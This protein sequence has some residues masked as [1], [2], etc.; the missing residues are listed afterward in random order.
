[1]QKNINTG[2]FLLK[3]NI[4]FFILLL[5]LNIADFYISSG[6]K[7][8]FTLFSLFINCSLFFLYKIRLS[9]I[10]NK[11]WLHIKKEILYINYPLLIT[12]FF[13]LMFLV[14]S[15][16]I[17]ILA[18]VNKDALNPAF[19]LTFFLST[20]T[21]LTPSIFFLVYIFIVNPALILPSYDTR[22]NKNKSDIIIIILFVIFILASLSKFTTDAINSL[23]IN[24]R[25]KFKAVKLPVSYS[26]K[27]LKYKDLTDKRINILSFDTIKVPLYYTAEG[28]KYNTYEEADFFCKSINARV[29]NHLEIYN[30]IFNRFDTF[31]EQYYWTSNYAGKY[32]LVLHFK[33]MSYEIEMKPKNI[34]PTLYCIS[35]NEVDSQLLD[36]KYFYRNKIIK[37]ENKIKKTNNKEYKF[38]PDI[39]EIKTSL[40]NT[41]QNTTPL[42]QK[43]PSEIRNVN[44][45]VKHVPEDVFNQLIKEGYNY[46]RTLKANPYY[47]KTDTAIS[48]TITN[49][50]DRT[51]I[52]LCYFPFIDDSN[53]SKEN[54]KEIWKQSFC[55]PSFEVT[56]QTPVLKSG[57]EKNA[58]CMANGGRVPNIPELAAILKV[59]EINDPA[60]K[61][62]TNNEVKNNTS[63][64]R[65]PI[66]V[67]YTGSDFIKPSIEQ[68]NENA[69]TFCIKTPKKQSKIISNFQS[70]FYNEYGIS[71]AKKICPSCVY[72]EMPDTVLLQ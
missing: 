22:K 7:E 72:Y 37:K 12:G 41:L 20:I 21:M 9:E 36:K 32:N 6:N 58:Y 24:K 45:C 62:W 27:Y 33:N 43:M 64:D 69:Y 19:I 15:A 52:N 61:F 23:T 8:K 16:N 71:Y 67:Q 68:K 2:N 46:N 44:F 60:A 55:S 29:P 1:M 56:K 42:F 40:E 3:T 65:V 54:Q 10:I 66:S 31:G 50:N 4:Q 11:Y 35:N 5:I 38:P 17:V 48:Q 49:N 51:Q 26:E 25:E 53:I 59:Y 30:I 57:Y 70:K 63:L 13:I 14:L 18:I 47:E 34:T 39:N 28:F